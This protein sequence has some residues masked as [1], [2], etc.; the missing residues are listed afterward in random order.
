MKNILIYWTAML[1]FLCV[2]C[3][4]EPFMNDDQA[5]RITGNLDTG[6]RTTFIQ[7]GNVT[8]THWVEGDQIGLYT[9]QQTNLLCRALSSGSIT[10]FMEGT[11]KLERTEGGKVWAYYPYERRNDGFIS[12]HTLAMPSDRP[13]PVLLYADATI[14]GQNVNFQFKHYFAYLKI[15]VSAELF[16]KL[17]EEHYQSD[18]LT[19][20]GSGIYITSTEPISCQSAELNLKNMELTN[21]EDCKRIIYRCRNINYEGEENYTF[22]IPMLPQSPEAEINICLFFLKKIED[23]YLYP[24]RIETKKVPQNGIQAGHVYQVNYAGNVSEDP[25]A[26]EILTKFYHA[27]GGE[28][29]YNNANWLSENSFN[30]WYG[31]N[32]G[33]VN[34]PHVHSL[35]L[36]YN[37]LTGQLPAELAVLMDK[38]ATIN[39][40]GN[41]LTG[42]IPDEIRNHEKWPSL[43]WGIIHQDYEKGG[44]FD[45]ANSNLYVADSPVTH[46]ADGSQTTLKELFSRNKLT[47]VITLEPD[48]KQMVHYLDAARVNHHL[49]YQSQGLGTL[50]F[51]GAEEEGE[52]AEF[53]RSINDMY[54][55]V[56]G[57]SWLYGKHDGK[58]GYSYFY[59][60]QG[61]LVY[62]A[63]YSRD[64][65][66]DETQKKLDTFLRSTLGEPSAHEEF[67]MKFYT[68][69][70]Y[71]MDGEIYA[72]Q[73]ATEGQGIDIILMGDGFTD[74]HMGP[75]GAY[76]SKMQEA[77]EKIFSIEPFKSFRNRFNVWVVKVV[78][79]NAEFSDDAVRA[80]EEQNTV[81]LTY[82]AL[83]ESPC[84]LVAV[85]YNT[86]SYVARSHC[87][88][89]W[90]GIYASCVAYCMEKIDGT[91][92][93]ELCGHGIVCLS[94]E[95][96]EPGN[97]NLTIPDD[98]KDA[99]I[100]H[101]WTRKWGFDG[102]VD[103]NSAASKVR[104]AHIL[105]DKRFA[106]ENLGVYE[107]A[108]LYGHGAYRSSRTSVMRG[109]N[110]P[111]FN[112]PSRELIY[113]AV[114]MRSE[115]DSWLNTYDYEDFVKFD[116]AAREEYANSRSVFPQ[117][118]DEELCEMNARHRPPT[119]IEG[120]W[121]DELKKGSIRVPL[122]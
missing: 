19:L 117:T 76:E 73:V 53:I 112:A 97:E 111:Y 48:V 50:L 32:S 5:L 59:D 108:W 40:E 11:E 66:N 38:A 13:V 63:P 2:S 80:I 37:N 6:S 88:M 7:D 94:D 54:G 8:H 90:D 86:E 22:L 27:T 30:E 91:L 10:E 114:M 33:Y 43:G 84:P 42:E 120:S 36:P 26:R 122:R 119:F 24:M 56:A 20:E 58:V 9:D 113:K 121:R 16:R 107:G 85:I 81:A 102:N 101:F 89:Y 95:Y 103:F 109:S 47:Q 106:D 75:G 49:D 23:N 64:T 69:S 98:V 78:S 104:W 51:T 15:T 25:Q 39:L 14:T 70:D 100:N 92:I 79:P 46:L 71:S 87:T 45:L 31:V 68:S 1:A 72:I 99:L 60:A 55:E 110:V 17:K 96:V 93:H 12:L 82:A 52:H 34:Y 105:S 28:K 57:T 83:T 65:D 118:T 29:W 77:T 62:I 116:E 21:G 115:G 3:I 44:G 74:R 4:D 35:D 18:E 67:Q 41:L 61:Q